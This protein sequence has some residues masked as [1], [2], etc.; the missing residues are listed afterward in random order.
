MTSQS[1]T[2]QD[3]TIRSNLGRVRDLRRTDGGDRLYFRS[4]RIAVRHDGVFV[5]TR[6]GVELGPFDSVFA[7]EVE[8]ELLVSALARLDPGADSVAG[9]RAFV[10][11][12]NEQAD[13]AFAG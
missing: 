10:S 6:E 8:A 2:Q 7:A 13:T 9:V 3:L 11:A 12:E 5:R 4:S 1:M